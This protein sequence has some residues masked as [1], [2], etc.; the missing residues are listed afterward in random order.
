MNCLGVLLIS[1]F[2]LWQEEMWNWEE[3]PK[4]LVPHTCSQYDSELHLPLGDLGSQCPLHPPP[5]QALLEL[6]GVFVAELGWEQGYCQCRRMIP[7]TTHALPDPYLT[8][9]S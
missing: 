1:T 5:D 6:L 8:L 4:A 3:G 9:V 7:R 2:D